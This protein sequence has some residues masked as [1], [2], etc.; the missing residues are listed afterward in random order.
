MAM[1]SKAR[2]RPT[3]DDDSFAAEEGKARA[4]YRVASQL[5]GVLD[6]K[7]SQADLRDPLHNRH[8][9]TSCSAQTL[10]S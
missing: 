6:P 3:W 8:H 2:R 5:S 10:P 1:D 7:V 9:L 4:S